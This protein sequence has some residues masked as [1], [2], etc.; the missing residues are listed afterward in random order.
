MARLGVKEQ[1]LLQD[2]STPLSPEGFQFRIEA[3]NGQSYYVAPNRGQL[4][5]GSRGDNAFTFVTVAQPGEGDVDL[6]TIGPCCN[7]DHRQGPEQYMEPAQPLAGED[8]VM[9]YV[10]PT[11]KRRHPRR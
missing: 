6:L 1:W 11:G 2:D 3:A 9:W 7:E 4:P 5:Q 8:L 10:P